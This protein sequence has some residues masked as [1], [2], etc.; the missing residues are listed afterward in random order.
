MFSA[1]LQ[2]HDKRPGMNAKPHNATEKAIC[3]GCLCFAQLHAHSLL[4]E[5]ESHLNTFPNDHGHN[6][7]VKD[8]RGVSVRRFQIKCTISQPL[9]CKFKCINWSLREDSNR[10]W[11]VWRSRYLYGLFKWIIRKKGNEKWIL[12]RNLCESWCGGW[13]IRD[14]PPKFSGYFQN[15]KHPPSYCAF[16]PSGLGW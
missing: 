1:D 6:R 5:N 14:S 16:P 7:D 4:L 2:W 9:G 8:V 15:L 3:I 12:N 10:P 11:M 13:I